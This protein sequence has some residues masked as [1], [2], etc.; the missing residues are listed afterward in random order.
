VIAKSEGARVEL[1]DVANDLDQA[2]L[3][4]CSAKKKHRIEVFMKPATLETSIHVNDQWV[5]GGQPHAV[6]WYCLSQPVLS[7]RL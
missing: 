4:V 7:N 6:A 2:T 3:V 5:I 1:L